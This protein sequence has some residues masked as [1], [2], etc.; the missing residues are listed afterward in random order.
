MGKRQLY[1][2]PKGRHVFLM[3]DNKRGE[4]LQPSRGLMLDFNQAPSPLA[5]RRAL[6]HAA[7]VAA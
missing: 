6:H 3:L 4:S 1:P 2:P 7:T 5:S